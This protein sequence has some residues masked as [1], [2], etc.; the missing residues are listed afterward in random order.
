M[1]RPQ[2]VFQYVFVELAGSASTAQVQTYAACCDCFTGCISEFKE[3]PASDK[4]S[5]F[6]AVSKNATEKDPFEVSMGIYV[7]KRDVLVSCSVDI[8]ARGQAGQGGG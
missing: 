4:L 5:D 6:K 3:K 1:H 2:Y 8:A 7:F